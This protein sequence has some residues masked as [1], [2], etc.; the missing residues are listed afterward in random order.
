MAAGG[1]PARPFRAKALGLV[2]AL[3]P[4]HGV[5]R[6]M[7]TRQERQMPVVQAGDAVVTKKPPP[8]G[9]II[10]TLVNPLEYSQAQI[11]KAC[12]IAFLLGRG[13]LT[14]CV[15]PEPELDEPG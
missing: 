3:F 4:S 7:L 11:D 12:A 5:H 6:H 2:D 1:V 13:K 10:E 15:A 8:P 9:V 14:L